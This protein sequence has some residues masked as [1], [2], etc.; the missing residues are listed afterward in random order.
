MKAYNYLGFNLFIWRSLRQKNN[1]K[2]SKFNSS[3]LLQFIK[4]EIFTQE[5]GSV[6]TL[7]SLIIKVCN[8]FKENYTFGM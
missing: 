1:S 2:L 3:H 4:V 7:I 6:I 8:L 5:G